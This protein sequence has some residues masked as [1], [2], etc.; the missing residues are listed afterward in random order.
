MKEASDKVVELCTAIIDFKE[1]Y[2]TEK[3]ELLDKFT[4]DVKY[5]QETLGQEEVDD[6]YYSWGVDDSEYPFSRSL[7]W[8]KNEGKV[9][10]LFS[11]DDNEEP[12]LGLNKDIRYSAMKKFNYF[13][14]KGLDVYKI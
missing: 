11:E 8:S 12:L 9:M 7:I 2:N 14:G 13:L 1:E 5:V 3:L 10:H 6:F 4:K